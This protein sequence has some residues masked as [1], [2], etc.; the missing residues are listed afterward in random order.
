MI[1]YNQNLL[2]GGY[3]PTAS[4]FKKMWEIMRA[5]LGLKLELPNED[6]QSYL[7]LH[8]NEKVKQII[9]KAEDELYCLIQEDIKKE[10]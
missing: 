1:K 3:M 2:D 6:N 9:K 8:E 5:E 4:D 10:S 7:H